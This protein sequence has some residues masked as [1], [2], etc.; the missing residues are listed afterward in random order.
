MPLFNKALVALLLVVSLGSAGCAGKSVALGSPAGVS[1]DRTQGRS[2]SGWASGFQ[3]F[4]L[5][6]IG[7]NKRHEK[8][9]A[10][11]LAEAGDDYLT[12]IR[13]KESWTYA[14]IGTIYRVE[15]DGMAY[16]RL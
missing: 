9:Y 10:A 15:L 7:I 5:I 2:V 13:V 14:L 6:P 12:D 11:L 4:L 1:Y 3:L 16:P 8:A